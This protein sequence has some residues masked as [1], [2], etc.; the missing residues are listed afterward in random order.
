MRKPSEEARIQS[1]FARDC[2]AARLQ[3]L[4]RV[5]VRALAHDMRQH[6]H[7]APRH[8]WPHLTAH[9]PQQDLAG[10]LRGVVGVDMRVGAVAGDDRRILDHR[11]VK[12]GVHVE[13]DRNRGL[14]VDRAD[15]AQQFALAILEA[16]GDHCAV[17]IEEHAVIAAFRNSITDHCGDVLVG[18][19]L[20]RARRRRRGGDRQHDVGLFARG[21][22]EIGA[23]PR[24]GAAIGLDRRLAVERARAPIR[25][26]GP[27]TGERRR[28]RREGVGLVLHHRDQEAHSGLPAAGG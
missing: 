4:V 24:A 10:A 25:I 2:G 22:I 14:R 18:A 28:Y 13:R 9:R 20:D 6:R 15:A 12:I 21:E 27:K 5:I 16:L 11:V 17:Q 26:T 3:F 8:D 19:I 7:I 1:R 23:E